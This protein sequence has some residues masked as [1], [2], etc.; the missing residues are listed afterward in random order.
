MLTSLR[1]ILTLGF[2]T[3]MTQTPDEIIRIKH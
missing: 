3:K 2:E 1:L